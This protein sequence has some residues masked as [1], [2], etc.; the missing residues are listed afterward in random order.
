MVSLEDVDQHG[1]PQIV[2]TY[3]QLGSSGSNLSKIMAGIGTIVQ[4]DVLVWNKFSLA[5]RRNV[6]WSRFFYGSDR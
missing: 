3:E 4:G 2:A 5:G 6:L 1:D